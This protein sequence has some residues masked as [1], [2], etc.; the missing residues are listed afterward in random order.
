M[1]QSLRVALSALA[2]GVHSTQRLEQKRD[3]LGCLTVC[4]ILNYPP[5]C[6]VSS[7]TFV[8]YIPSINFLYTV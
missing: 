3:F 7:K 2:C 5:S 4:F 8:F 1:Q 6:H